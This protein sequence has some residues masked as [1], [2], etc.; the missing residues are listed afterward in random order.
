MFR[1]EMLMA[2]S[3]AK[4]KEMNPKLFVYG[5]LLQPLATRV[6]RYLQANGELLGDAFA[7]GRLYDLGHY[8]GLWYDAGSIKQ[9]YGQVVRLKNPEK[10]LKML[11]EYEGIDPG[12]PSR[13][14][15]RREEVLA[16]L[17][18]HPVLCWC[19]LL[20]RPPDGLP[21]IFGGNYLD[22]IEDNGPHRDFLKSV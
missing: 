2:E 21:E 20:N 3:T 8:P 7:P 12:N 5:S 17:N 14:E 9:I 4:N 15:Y 1:E 11:D 16:S 18:G 22:Y 19:Y 6:G 13:G 10:A